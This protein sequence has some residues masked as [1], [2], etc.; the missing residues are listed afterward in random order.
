MLLNFTRPIRL[1][2]KRFFRKVPSTILLHKRF[3]N[4]GFIDVI[5]KSSL[6]RHRYL[7]FFNYDVSIIDAESLSS[8]RDFLLH[9]SLLSSLIG[10]IKTGKTV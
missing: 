3:V 7:C 9:L 2:N 4:V 6:L 8:Y 5:N 1:I 10:K